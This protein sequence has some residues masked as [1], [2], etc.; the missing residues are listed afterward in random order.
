MLQATCRTC[1]FGSRIERNWTRPIFGAKSNGPAATSI[2]Y[3]AVE[4]K[5]NKLP[6]SSTCC[7][8]LWFLGQTARDLL[9]WTGLRERRMSTRPTF[10]RADW[11]VDL[12]SD[13]LMDVNAR[14]ERVQLLIH[15]NR[16]DNV[17]IVLSVHFLS[18]CRSYPLALTVFFQQCLHGGVIS[19]T[20]LFSC[21]TLRAR[22]NRETVALKITLH[23]SVSDFDAGRRID[24]TTK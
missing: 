21:W 19:Y 24:T 10:I 9:V 3:T 23:I 17:F 1:C 18:D 2:A 15:W 20:N 12:V 16:Y 14:L 13:R 5:G 6:V 7:V 8:G 4:H 22:Q 11:F